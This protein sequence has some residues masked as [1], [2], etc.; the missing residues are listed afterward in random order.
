MSNDFASAF[1]EAVSGETAEEKAEET[2]EV[3]EE[4]V[5]EEV[6]AEK[7]EEVAPEEPVAEAVEEAPATP[8]MSADDLKEFTRLQQYEKSNE[9]RVAA[10]QRKVTELQH[11]AQ[12]TPKTPAPAEIPEASKEK[13]AAFEKEYPEIA[14]AMN[15]K[16]TSMQ[17]QL[18]TT[19]QQ[20]VQPLHKAEQNRYIQ[21]QADALEAAH[22]GWRDIAA[23][24]QFGG[25]MKQQPPAV[26]QMLRSS[27]ASDAAYLIGAYKSTL[28]P[29]TQDVVE[30]P[31]EESAQENVSEIQA[32]REKRLK[33][34]QGIKS[35]PSPTAS[36]G[37]PQDFESAF[38]YFAAQGK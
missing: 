33:E 14:Q 35:K 31:K 26:Q 24:E 8:A 28:T 18:D 21:G 9:G 13:W 25:W 16:L 2:T 30:V 29:Q 34:S 17:S 11:A 12:Q 20:T 5:A 3:V 1:K 36:G 10:Y 38:K 27:T 4:V 32:Q 19:V 15:A 6:V 37:V 22:P 23:S 7:A